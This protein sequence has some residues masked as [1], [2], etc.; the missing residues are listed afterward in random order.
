MTKADTYDSAAGG[1]DFIVGNKQINKYIVIEVG[2]GEKSFSQ[3]KNTAK[4]M[5]GNLLYGFNVSMTKLS[6]DQS[7]QFVSIPLS[8][9][10]LI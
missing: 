9:F 5:G 8:Y 3:L 10:L 6:I 4:R 7:Q 2:S 1:A